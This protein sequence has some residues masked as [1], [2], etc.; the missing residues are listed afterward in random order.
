MKKIYITLMLAL[1]STSVSAVPYEYPDTTG[2]KT[3]SPGTYIGLGFGSGD[4]G[5]GLSKSSPFELIGGYDVNSKTSIEVSYIDF[6]EA[7][8]GIPPVFRFDASALAFGVLYKIPANE[9]FDVEF[10][11]GLNLWDI[12][13]SID[14]IGVVF[15]DSG[16]GLFYGVGAST[17]IN[18]KLRLG[19]RYISY[20]VDGDPISVISLNL[21]VGL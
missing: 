14:G 11:I 13:L 17:N 21:F 6:G 15:T 2:A 8:D 7:D 1:F 3:P 4:Y 5:F 16:T 10:K 20:D 19:A 18:D 9:N 12:E